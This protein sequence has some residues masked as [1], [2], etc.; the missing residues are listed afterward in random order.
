MLSGLRQVAVL[1]MDSIVGRFDARFASDMVFGSDMRTFADDMP[2][3]E[4]KLDSRLAYTKNNRDMG[5]RNMSTSRHTMSGGGA[6]FMAEVVSA[7]CLSVINVSTYYEGLWMFS[8]LDSVLLIDYLTLMHTV[9][10]D[11]GRLCSMALL[12]MRSCI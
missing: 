1:L 5:E 4:R 3:D 10:Q 2:L 8:P 12:R 6:S 11:Y 9:F 7:L